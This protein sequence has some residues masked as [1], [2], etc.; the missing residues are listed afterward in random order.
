MR[1]WTNRATPSGLLLAVLFVLWLAARVMPY[2][3]ITYALASMAVFDLLFNTALVVAV[4]VPV[5]QARA[6]RQTAIIGKVVLMLLGNTAFYAGLFGWWQNGVQFGLYFGLYLI[7]AL[8]L[9]VGR[10]VI[11]FFTE[12]GVGY[13]VTLVNR[14]WLD[15]GGLVIFIVFFVSDL[16]FDAQRFAAIC[17]LALFVLNGIRIAGWHTPGIWRKPLL[18][19]L[20]AGYA[21]IIAG[22]LLYA[23]SVFTGVTKFAAVHAFA[24]GGI[25]ILTLSMMSRVSLGHTGRNVQEPHR[26]L[27]FIFIALVLGAVIRVV[28]VLFDPLHYVLYIVLSQLLWMLAFSG[29]VWIYTPVLIRPRIDGQPG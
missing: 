6:W 19:S 3:P 1:N 20:F 5:I 4:T 16:F 12:R 23:L 26:Y 17:A 22:F 18:W 8:I 24:Y 28:P 10:R 7:I 15:I 29:F 21:F 14:R 27:N 13:P 2:L 11:P 25:G 9:T